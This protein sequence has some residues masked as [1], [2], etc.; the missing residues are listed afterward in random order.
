MDSLEINLL[1]VHESVC[2]LSTGLRMDSSMRHHVGSVFQE[3][4]TLGSH[5]NNLTGILPTTH[6]CQSMHILL[7]SLYWL[8][9]YPCTGG[10]R[11]S[12]G[13]RIDYNA[14]FRNA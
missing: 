14:L 4:I 6:L 11:T 10:N 8:G 3:D 9:S 1:G 5:Q 13:Y 2:S 7:V 12:H